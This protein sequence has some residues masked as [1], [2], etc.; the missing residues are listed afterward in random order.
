MSA[1]ILAV[2]HRR[3]ALHRSWPWM[4]DD[5]ILEGHDAQ[6]TADHVEQLSW[7]QQELRLSRSSEA[8]IPHRERLVNQYA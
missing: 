7:S 5:Q 6:L 4:I 2:A 1:G 8:V 3:N